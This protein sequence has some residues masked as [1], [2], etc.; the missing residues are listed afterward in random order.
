M[1]GNA[2]PPVSFEEGDPYSASHVQGIQYPDGQ[3]NY[4]YQSFPSGSSTS[5]SPPG[6]TQTAHRQSYHRH[7]SY[8]YDTGNVHP[9]KSEHGSGDSPLEEGHDDAPKE[10]SFSTSGKTAAATSAKPVVRAACLSCRTAK[11]RCDGAQPVCG[12]CASRGVTAESAACVF[13]ASKRGGPRFKG[14]TGEEAKRIKAEKEQKKLERAAGTGPPSS[15]ASSS[16]HDPSLSS[17]S[18]HYPASALASQTHYFPHGPHDQMPRDPSK[19]GYDHHDASAIHPEQRARLESMP[20][21]KASSSRDSATADLGGVQQSSHP[22]V[23]ADSV[24]AH[25]ITAAGGMHHSKQRPDQHTLSDW[26]AAKVDTVSPADVFASL[27]AHDFNAL[28]Q[29]SYAKGSAQGGNRPIPVAPYHQPAVYENGQSALSSANLELWQKIQNSAAGLQDVAVPTAASD[30]APGQNGLGDFWSRLERLPKA[31]QVG[32]GGEDGPLKLLKFDSEDRNVPL[33]SADSEQQ[34][35]FLLTAFFDKVYASA[36]VLLA[37]ENLSSLAFW[38][39]GKGPCALYAA[40][41]ALVTLRLP[42]HEAYKTLRGGYQHGADGGQRMTKAEIA[43]HHA[44]TS[45]FLL[46]RFSQQ[47][48][49]AAAASFGLDPNALSSGCDPEEGGRAL[50]QGP[51]DPELLRIEAAAAHTLLCH[52]FYSAGGHAAQAVAHEHALEA[53]NSLQGIRIELQEDA[54]PTTPLATSHFN[55]EQKQEWAKRVYWTSFAAASVTACTGGFHPI[56]FTCDAVT[57]LKLRPAL[58]SDVGAWG[59]FI[60]GAQHVARG[61]TAL[62]DLQALQDKKTKHQ[63]ISQEEY[64]Q[65]RARVYMG[66]CKLD[67]DMATFSAYDPAWRSEPGTIF[68]SG[69]QSLGYALR[70]AGKLMTAGATVIIHRG[71]AFANAHIFMHPQCGLPKAARVQGAKLVS[72]DVDQVVSSLENMNAGREYQYS[73]QRDSSAMDLDTSSDPPSPS[74][75]YAAPPLPDRLW[76]RSGS[77]SLPPAGAG[78]ADSPMSQQQ[79][80]APPPPPPRS[81]SSSSHSHSQGAGSMA[82]SPA[83]AS[84]FYN[85]GNEGSG[86]ALQQFHLS[87]NGSGGEGGD[88]YGSRRFSQQQRSSTGSGGGMGGSAHTDSPNSGSGA[89]GSAPGS[90]SFDDDAYAHGPFEPEHSVAKCKWAADSMLESVRTLMRSQTTEDGQTVFPLGNQADEAP[91]LPPWAACSYVLGAYCILMQCLVV[92]AARAWKRANASG[93]G[94]S[95]DATT[96]TGQDTVMTPHARTAGGGESGGGRSISS[97][98]G[99]APSS[100]GST[101]VVAPTPG[102]SVTQSQEELDGEL[103]RLQEQV[104]AVYALLG[105]FAKTHN[106]AKEYQGEVGMLLD[107]NRRL[108]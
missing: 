55:W 93:R 45:Q 11:R 47:Q 53:W 85:G 46:R 14:C 106:I 13:V 37:P 62:Y 76:H 26:Q 74:L 33:D 18:P 16:R 66:L 17:M 73:Q 4:P 48:A 6:P 8:S 64:I 81:F 97:L 107:I 102:T 36:P 96:A 86:H 79:P 61:Y 65:E 22:L 84:G 105:R 98:Q 67:R 24:A 27:A 104:D 75:S 23:S 71:Q 35:R 90:R 54:L 3:P 69:Q 77:M 21:S 60:R 88:T 42:E 57:A 31:G 83:A 2:P 103:R 10:A 108:Q 7:P 70:T 49:A 32:D 43:A 94:N 41:S 58:E 59:V 28:H 63:E 80:Q 87:G 72:H 92:Q 12:P 29:A 56:Q 40:I 30:M 20:S 50:C 19:R 15:S 82:P 1:A 68:D 39:S 91:S 5:S 89:G 9:S 78:S 44:R 38:F 52:Y 51:T 100:V 101:P 95:A 25:A 99:A 34:A